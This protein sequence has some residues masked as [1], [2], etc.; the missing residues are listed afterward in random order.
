MNSKEMP[1]FTMIE[2]AQFQ[3]TNNQNLSHYINNTGL[4]LEYNEF[5]QDFSQREISSILSKISH[6][7]LHDKGTRPFFTSVCINVR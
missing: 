3:I 7:P 2:N 5:S 4:E 6:T 1:G